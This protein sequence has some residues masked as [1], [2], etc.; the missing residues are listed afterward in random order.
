LSGAS[1]ENHCDADHDGKVSDRMG[2][3]RDATLSLLEQ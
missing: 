3:Q 2:T 1:D